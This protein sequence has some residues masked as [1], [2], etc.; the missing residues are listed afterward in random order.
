KDDT[1]TSQLQRLVLSSAGA[2][3]AKEGAKST[4]EPLVFTSANS[5]LMS[6]FDVSQQPNPIAL[7]DKFESQDTVYTLAARLTGPVSSAFP[8][9][10]PEKVLEAQADDAAREAL[11]AAH[12][13]D[14]K[15]PVNIILI[16]DVDM[17]ADQNWAQV[18]DVAGERVAVPTANNADFFINA[19][20]NVRGNQGLVSLR[21]RGLTIRPFTVIDE[22]RAVADNQFRAKEQELL[23]RISEMEQTIEKLQR[24]E[25]STGVLLTSQQQAEIDNFRVEMLSLRRELRDVQLSLR[26]NVETLEREVRLINIWA[27]PLLV[28]LLAIVLAVVRRIRRARYHRAVLH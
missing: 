25:Q 1:L 10:P 4:L 24:E 13:R 9:G 26:K 12:L 22:M 3:T 17:L 16:G 8:D 27:V 18:R 20:D 11:T 23:G 21:G 19:I 6:A 5:D 28:A 7:R 15:T 2:F 14:A